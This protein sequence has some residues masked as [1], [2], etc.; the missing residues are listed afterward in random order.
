MVGELCVWERQCPWVKGSGKFE[1]PDY[2]PMGA[3]PELL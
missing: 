2:F 3:F 1:V